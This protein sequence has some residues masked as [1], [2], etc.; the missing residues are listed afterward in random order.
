MPMMKRIRDCLRPIFR[1]AKGMQECK[2]SCKLEGDKLV[3]NRVK[4]GIEDIGKLP[5][6]LSV[7]LAAE[8]SD[9]KT[10]V[11]HGEL[12]P[13]SNFHSSPSTIKNEKFHS[14]EQWIQYQKCLWSGDSYTANMILKSE[15][16]LKAKHLSSRIKDYDPE[17]WRNDGHN[18]CFTSIKE[19]FVQN[20]LL[21]NM[22]KATKP[23]TLTKASNDKVW[24][25]GIPLR[26]FDVLKEDKWYGRGWLSET[27]HTI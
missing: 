2:D 15:D 19:K 3:I 21:M 18:V 16:P 20:Q 26:D 4:Y 7:Y 5:A 9:S 23:K 8:K 10:I 1:M 25:T 6:N 27:L 17:R 14:T 13:Y 22:L 12:S 11:F 24:E